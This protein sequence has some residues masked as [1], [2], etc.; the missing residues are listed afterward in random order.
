MSDAQVDQ[1][2]DGLGENA[3]LARTGH[4]AGRTAGSYVSVGHTS[5]SAHYRGSPGT[6]CVN[7]LPV[8]RGDHLSKPN[9]HF[10]FQQREPWDT[11][12]CP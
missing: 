2:A 5:H 10:T 8:T 1:R 11:C 4:P 12:L 3:I 6:P 9:E 7:T